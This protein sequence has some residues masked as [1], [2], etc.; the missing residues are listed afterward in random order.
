MISL[1]KLPNPNPR[2]ASNSSYLLQRLVPEA[3]CQPWALKLFENAKKFNWQPVNLSQLSI[4]KRKQQISILET[5]QR[6][7][8][9]FHFRSRFSWVLS[10]SLQAVTTSMT[11]VKG[12]TH[13]PDC[14]VK[15][16]PG[17]CNGYPEFSNM[18]FLC[19]VGLFLQVFLWQSIQRFRFVVLSGVVLCSLAFWQ[20]R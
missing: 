20:R 19:F 15:V 12:T 16:I 6:S 1:P 8:H 5:P 4:S 2:A 17:Q 3:Y 18:A 11:S 7:W 9:L 13:K 14:G 10:N